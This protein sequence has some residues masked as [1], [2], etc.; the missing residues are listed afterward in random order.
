MNQ[1]Y[2]VLGYFN[3]VIDA[4]NAYKKAKEK[5]IKE[6]AQKNFDNGLINE[7]VYQALMNYEVEITD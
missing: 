3:N 2:V 6:I 1:E 5:H 4:F 7:Q